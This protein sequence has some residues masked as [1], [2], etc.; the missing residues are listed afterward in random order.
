MIPAKKDIP[1]NEEPRKGS[2]F[3]LNKIKELSIIPN[4][5]KDNCKEGDKKKKIPLTYKIGQI[6]IL[7]IVP[8]VPKEEKL[9]IYP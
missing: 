8:K 1:K 3:N 7:N 2:F 5:I 4:A 6:I 9:G